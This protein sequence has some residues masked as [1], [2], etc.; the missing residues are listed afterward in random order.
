MKRRALTTK[1]RQILASQQGIVGVASELV[2]VN[3]ADQP[4][5]DY[6]LGTTVVVKSLAE[7]TVV[8]RALNHSL[9]IVT[10]AGDIVNAGGSMSGGANQQR[11]IGLLEQKQQ[12]EKLA[13]NIDLM[14][15]KLATVELEGNE[16]KQQLTASKQAV[17]QLAPKLQRPKRS[18]NNVNS[19]LIL[20]KLN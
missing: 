9:R 14:K 7:A 10:L 3:A 12:L 6:L 17:Q 13:A 15:S 2:T 5:L 19:S 18:C 11:K 8:A 16:A 1:Q 4:I 20:V